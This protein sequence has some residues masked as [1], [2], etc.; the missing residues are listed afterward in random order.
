M[1]EGTLQCLTS[2]SACLD[3][4]AE[5]LRPEP[6]IVV[7]LKRV[8]CLCRLLKLGPKLCGHAADPES[9]V[10]ECWPLNAQGSDYDKVLVVDT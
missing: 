2:R 3:E 1:A 7:P 6:Q 9:V 5:Q 8:D 10:F 4:M